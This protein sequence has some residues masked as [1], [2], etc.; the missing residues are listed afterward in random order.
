MPISYNK[1]RA[2]HTPVEIMMLVFPSRI[3]RYNDEVVAARGFKNFRV[4]SVT[5]VL[6]ANAFGFAQALL[7]VARQA[8]HL[9]YLFGSAGFTFCSNKAAVCP[10]HGIFIPN[11]FKN[12]VRRWGQG[13]FIEHVT[14]GLR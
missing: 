11:F 5:F 8:M 1:G 4:F 3:S 9:D 12:A 6:M 7:L 14:S 2:L 13:R 10:H